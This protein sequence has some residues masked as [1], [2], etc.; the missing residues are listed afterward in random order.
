MPELSALRRSSDKRI[1]GGICG[2]VAEWLGMSPLLVR[3]LFIGVSV[4]SA[5]FPGIVVYVVLWF[6]I[7]EESGSGSVR[8]KRSGALVVLL[9]V[10][11]VM[12]VIIFAIFALPVMLF[13][14]LDAL[15]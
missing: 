2:G 11:T 9:L 3:L 4:L 1:L 13:G 7:P 15:N 5:A 12:V 14:L 6:V 8:P 10:L